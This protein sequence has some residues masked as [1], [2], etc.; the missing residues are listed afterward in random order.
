MP[1][2]TLLLTFFGPFPGVPVNPSGVTARQVADLLAV[3]RPTLRVITRQLPVSYA[4]SSQDIADALQQVRPDALISLGVAVG[5]SRVSIEKVAINC[6]SANIADNEGVVLTDAPIIAGGQEAYFSTLPVRASYERLHGE[7]LPVEISYTA[8]TYVCNHV[9]YEGRRLV[10]E[11][12]LGIP[13][14]FVHIPASRPDGSGQNTG[15]GLVAHAQDG[16]VEQVGEQVPTLPE[17]VIARIVAEIASDA[18]PG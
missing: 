8:G 4:G 12:G 3:E 10:D 9:F 5:R 7:G 16:G 15:A 11:L 6:D 18:V 13:A 2:S 17:S 14:G 1:T